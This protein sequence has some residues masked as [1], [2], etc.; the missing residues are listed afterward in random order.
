MFKDRVPAQMNE[1]KHL[2]DEMYQAN[3]QMWECVQ[4]LREDQLTID[5][6]DRNGSIRFQLVQMICNENLWVN[7]LWH[8]EVEYLQ[9]VNFPTLAQIRLEWDA[10]EV[11]LRD[12][13]ATLSPADLACTVELDSL[14]LPP[15]NLSDILLRVVTQATKYR[16]QILL[17]IHQ[18]G[19][20]MIL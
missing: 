11:E 16:T 4:E 1:L 17:G 19:S 15:H 7:F 9:E 2:F 10:L 12:Y 14:N 18:L 3:H 5:L 13:L 20:P 8:G 6:G